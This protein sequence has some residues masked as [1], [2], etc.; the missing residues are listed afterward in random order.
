MFVFMHF[1][2]YCSVAI[3]RICS[4]DLEILVVHSACDFAHCLLNPT[5]KCVGPVFVNL[6]SVV[7]L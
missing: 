2:H 5:L 3:T 4:C 6:A 7:G 1:C